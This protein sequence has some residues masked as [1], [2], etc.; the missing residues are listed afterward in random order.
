M[1]AAPHVIK[2]RSTTYPLL[3]RSRAS[4]FQAASTCING[5]CGISC[6]RHD[7]HLLFCCYI[8]YLAVLVWIFSDSRAAALVSQYGSHLCPQYSAINTTVPL[9]DEYYSIVYLLLMSSLQVCGTI[10]D[11][12]MLSLG[13]SSLD[14]CCKRSFYF[15]GDLVRESN[16][17]NSAIP[18]TLGNCRA[19]HIIFRCI[20]LAPLHRPININSR[21][22]YLK[23]TCWPL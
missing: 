21:Y 17:Q 4:W 20:P 12:H 5:R 9:T 7:L 23:D 11:G 16:L 14:T 2:S 15:R 13:L 8:I 22:P 18:G 1:T 3:A 10:L 19:A 6:Y